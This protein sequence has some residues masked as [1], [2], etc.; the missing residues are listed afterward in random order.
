MP[1]SPASV[2]IIAIDVARQQLVRA[3]GARGFFIHFYD[4]DGDDVATIGEAATGTIQWPDS[5][6]SI[7]FEHQMETLH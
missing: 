5:Q 1:S 3:D 7:A 2:E 6:S 4:A